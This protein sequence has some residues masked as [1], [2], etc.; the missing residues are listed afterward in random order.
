[1]SGDR[2]AKQP[3][4]KTNGKGKVWTKPAAPARKASLERTNTHGSKSSASSV[5]DKSRNQASGVEHPGKSGRS[6]IFNPFL[7]EEGPQLKHYMT[8]VMCVSEMLFHDEFDYSIQPRSSVI[9]YAPPH[10][11]YEFIINQKFKQ[12]SLKQLH[13]LVFIT[14]ISKC[15]YVLN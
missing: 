10:D 13:V 5:S 9:Q 2:P 14:A 8:M 4:R 6:L 3:V 12:K 11:V 1:M 7:V 15:Y